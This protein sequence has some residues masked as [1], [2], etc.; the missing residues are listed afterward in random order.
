M[1]NG[2]KMGIST[3]SALP[4]KCC[5]TT[6]RTSLSM[7]RLSNMRTHAASKPHIHAPPI[8]AQASSRGYTQ[9]V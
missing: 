8:Q 1:P 9:P 4:H 6:I 7:A 2:M 5:T 3:N